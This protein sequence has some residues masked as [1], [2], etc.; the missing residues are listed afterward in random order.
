MNIAAVVRTLGPIDVR[1]VYRDSALKW[2]VFLPVLSALV[3]RFG[4]PPLTRRLLLTSG[5]DLVPYYPAILAY[6]IVFTTPLVFGVLVGFLLL[7]EKDDGTL[8][9]LQVSPLPLN[10]YLAYRVAIPI[11]LTVGMVFLLFPLAGLDRFRPTLVAGAAV[12]AAPQAPL[13][14]LFLAALAS[15]KVQGFALMKVT[16]VVLAAPLLAFFLDSRWELLLGIVP[17]YWPMRVYWGLE[18]GES[19]VWWAMVIALA[20]P[21]LLAALLAQRLYRSLHR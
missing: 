19:G 2:M 12:A 5:F 8:T 11:A 4:I 1:N 15:N 21:C 6:F 9:A 20:Y 7:D 16:G 13:S 18:A 14:A 10:R 3:L 17:T